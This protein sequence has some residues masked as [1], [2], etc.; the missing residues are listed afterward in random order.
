MSVTVDEPSSLVSQLDDFENIALT[1]ILTVN[2][3]ALDAAIGRVLPDSIV[4]P[5]PVARF[6]SAI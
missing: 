2:A 4:K 6:G 3:T 5:V 1:D